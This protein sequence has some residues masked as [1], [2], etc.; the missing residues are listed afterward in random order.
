MK[1]DTT[2]N[3]IKHLMSIRNLRQ[4]DILD[5]TKPYCERYG[6][7]LSKSDLSQYVSGSV[8]P[9]QSKLAVLGMA[10]NVNEVWLM[11]YDVPMERTDTDTFR[12]NEIDK[13][14]HNEDNLLSE[15]S[16]YYST[17]N[18]NIHKRL[19]K[20]FNRLNEAGQ[21]EAVNRVS[22]LT[23]IPQYIEHNVVPITKKPN[24]YI[25]TEEDIKS[26]VA[27]NGR[28]LTREEAIDI[29]STLF[30]DDEEE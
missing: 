24:K 30:S 7:K 25:P 23:Y 5:M 20:E 3:R 9:G 21:N 26:L 29:I 12:Y 2:A 6:M 14:I 19:L 27:R 1:I 8:E 4:V 15:G 28:K 13:S 11:G 17:S 18:D 16:Q 22:E 10:L